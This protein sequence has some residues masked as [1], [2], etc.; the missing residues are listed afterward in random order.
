MLAAILLAVWEEMQFDSHYRMPDPQA[1]SKFCNDM[2]TTPVGVIVGLFHAISQKVPA[3]TD[4]DTRKHG[5]ILFDNV[6]ACDAMTDM[7]THILNHG[8]LEYSATY[9]ILL[10][11]KSTRNISPQS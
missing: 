2:E 6:A 1:V 9:N 8:K 11:N 5:H 4:W 10:T 7:R 3:F